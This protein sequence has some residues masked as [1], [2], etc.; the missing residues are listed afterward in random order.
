M[1]L[2]RK[3]SQVERAK[4]GKGGCACLGSRGV[5]SLKQI[6]SFQQ[7]APP[8]TCAVSGVDSC[9]D[10]K[11][12]PRKEEKDLWRLAKRS[13]RLERNCRKR[14]NVNLE[15]KS[16]GGK[17]RPPTESI[18]IKEKRG[19]YSTINVLKKVT[20]GGGGEHL[21]RRGKKK[22]KRCDTM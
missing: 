5:C 14:G 8:K 3:K 13:A 10:K 15:K 1:F 7:K 18:P 16:P 6:K 2:L 11:E 9:H 12:N 17:K 4:K 22:R 19:S 21:D 20:R